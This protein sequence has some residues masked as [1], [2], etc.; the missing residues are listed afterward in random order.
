MLTIDLL[1]KLK[2]KYR[3]HRKHMLAREVEAATTWTQRRQMYAAGV[4]PNAVMKR[5]DSNA[6]TVPTIG[7]PP[8]PPPPPP[9]PLPTMQHF[10]R[11]LH[12]W[13]HPPP[14]V[15]SPRVPMWP[16]HL[17]PRTPAPPWA[18]P[19]PSD[20]AFWHHVYMRVS[21]HLCV[22]LYYFRMHHHKLT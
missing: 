6:W 7:F 17:V 10:G 3:S 9:P 13:G 12:V 8:P 19:P 18:P 22:L 11:P 20:P 5:P 21:T 16:R 1:S 14:T 15:E 2:Q 4:A